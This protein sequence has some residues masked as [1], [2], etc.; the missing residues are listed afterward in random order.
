MSLEIQ[1]TCLIDEKGLDLAE[2]IWLVLKWEGLPGGRGSCFRSWVPSGLSLPLW[3]TA[4]LPGCGLYP[5][6]TSLLEIDCWS[7]SFRIWAWLLQEAGESARIPLVAMST[8]TGTNLGSVPTVVLTLPKTELRKPPRLSWVP[9]PN[10]SSGLGWAL[11]ET[12][13]VKIKGFSN[14]SAELEL[15]D[16]SRMQA[17]SCFG[18]PCPPC[19][20]E[21]LDQRRSLF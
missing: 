8:P 9:S 17:S 16:R 2:L 19:P 7:Y 18:L 6:L 20:E 4:G 21:G 15:N 1:L 13:L 14:T 5:N 12:T 11:S 10:I 3:L